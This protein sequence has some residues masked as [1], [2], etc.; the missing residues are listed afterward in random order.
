MMASESQAVM[1]I[2]TIETKLR[3]RSSRTPDGRILISRLVHL[4]C[5]LLSCERSL[6]CLLALCKRNKD[7]INQANI[8][9]TICACICLL[10]GS[11][12]PFAHLLG[13]KLFTHAIPVAWRLYRSYGVLEALL[14]PLHVRVFGF[15][16][17]HFLMMHS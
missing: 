9:P 4:L 13:V 8:E 14:E 3:S 2:R 16:F 1:L 11:S 7:N 15:S 5:A 10:L 6:S 12:D 17:P